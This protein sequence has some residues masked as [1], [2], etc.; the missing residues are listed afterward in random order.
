MKYEF[1]GETVVKYGVTF[2]RIRAL[3][4]IGDE[5]WIPLVARGKFH[6]PSEDVDVCIDARRE[7]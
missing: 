2:K 5:T 6:T 1:T 7:K 4:D 3:R